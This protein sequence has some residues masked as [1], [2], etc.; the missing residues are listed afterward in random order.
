M[1]ERT[2]G[3]VTVKAEIWGECIEVD[4]YTHGNGYE[5]K[6]TYRNGD[7]ISS[8]FNSTDVEVGAEGAVAHDKRRA[9]EWARRN[10]PNAMKRNGE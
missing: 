1:A 10:W 5:R 9:L 3:C 7:C 4:I 8:P 2:F 6:D